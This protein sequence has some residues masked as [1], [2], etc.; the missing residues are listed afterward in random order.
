MEMKSTYDKGANAAY[1]Y[2]DEAS[3][4]RVAQTA[5]KNIPLDA[6]KSIKNI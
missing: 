1:I 3:S 6:L 2:L 5:S 4:G